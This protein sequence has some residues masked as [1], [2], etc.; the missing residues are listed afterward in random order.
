M[1]HF[2]PVKQNPAEGIARPDYLE[3]LRTMRQLLIDENGI[4]ILF[5]ADPE[6]RLHSAEMSDLLVG[7]EQAI[8]F[9]DAIVF[10]SATGE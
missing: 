10:Q 2:I 9:D 4:L 3:E 1:A 7:L 6:A 8:K 5:G